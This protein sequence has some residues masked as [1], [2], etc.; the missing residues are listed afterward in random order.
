MGGGVQ[1]GLGGMVL[2]LVLSWATGTDFLSLLSNGG[3]V[4]SSQSSGQQPGEL[5][6]TPEEE[7]LVDMVDVV[8]GDTQA[9]WRQ[10]LG[11]RKSVV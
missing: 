1:L 9:T 5:Q 3:G 10:I 11:D 8:A 4:P 6:T 2:L 7:R